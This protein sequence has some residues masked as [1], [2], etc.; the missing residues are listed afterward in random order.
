MPPEHGPA[1]GDRLRSRWEFR[2]LLAGGVSILQPDVSLT[3]VAVL[4]K[5]ARMAEPFEVAVAPH[6]PNHPVS[7]AAPVLIAWTAMKGPG[8][9]ERGPALEPGCRGLRRSRDDGLPGRPVS[10]D[11]QRGP[12]ARGTGAPGL[13]V[14]ID[15]D[16]VSAADEDWT[17]REPRW[18]LDDSRL[19]EW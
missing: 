5:I 10:A 2:D 7:L 12:V 13:G 6:C 15:L 16:A 9:A 19:A 8:A 18:L 4:E 1:T 17:L 14:Q 11:R 3:G